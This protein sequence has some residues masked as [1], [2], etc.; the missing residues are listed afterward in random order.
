MKFEVDQAKEV[1]GEVE[2]REGEQV[3]EVGEVKD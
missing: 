2:Q 3:E 1:K